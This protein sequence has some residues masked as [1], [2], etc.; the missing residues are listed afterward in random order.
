MACGF[1]SGVLNTSLGTNGPPLVF[2]LQARAIDANTFRATISMVFVFGNMLALTLFVLDGKVTADDL[3]G[4]ADRRPGVAARAG[5][6]L[7]DPPARARRALP[8]AR[9]HA[10]VRGRHHR[11]RVRRDVKPPRRTVVTMSPDDGP[12]D[13]AAWD[14]LRAICSSLAERDREDQ[15]RRA[16]LVRRIRQAAPA[17]SRRRGTTITTT[18]TRW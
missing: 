13:P 3:P 10:A 2:D 15:S 6:R 12:S 7:A 14:A 11:D 17:S 1:T 4:G 9:A 18:A 8:L 5:A 16:C